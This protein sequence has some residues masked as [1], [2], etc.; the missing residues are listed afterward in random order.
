[1]K[2]PAKVKIIDTHESLARAF[3][4]L[5]RLLETNR[6]FAAMAL[7][8]PIR[9]LEHIGYKLSPEMQDHIRHSVP[10]LFAPKG[11]FDRAVHSTRGLPWMVGVRFVNGPRTA[12]RLPRTRAR[13]GR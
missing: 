2:S 3:P 10:T 11:Q 7:T 13:T 8:D 9:A 12:R 1:V 6:H 4:H 5:G